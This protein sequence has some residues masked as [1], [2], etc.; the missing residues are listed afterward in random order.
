LSKLSSKWP[1]KRPNK[2]YGKHIARFE[3]A[4]GVRQRLS[5]SKASVVLFTLVGA[6]FVEAKKRPKT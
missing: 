5:P 6:A 4:R 3:A 2:L 1:N